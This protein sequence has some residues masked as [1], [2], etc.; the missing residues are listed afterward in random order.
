MN[1]SLIR[2][3]LNTFMPH[4]LHHGIECIVTA[5]FLKLRRCDLAERA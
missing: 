1:C 3:N 5:D 2:I 4:S